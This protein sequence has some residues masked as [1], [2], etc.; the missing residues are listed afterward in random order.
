MNTPSTILGRA[1]VVLATAALCL[2]ATPALADSA[3]THSQPPH[4]RITPIKPPGDFCPKP[5]PPPGWALP[6]Y[7]DIVLPPKP[8]MI[9]KPIQPPLL[10]AMAQAETVGSVSVTARAVPPPWPYPAPYPAPWPDPWPSPNP[11]P[12]PWPSPL[13]GPTF[14]VNV[15]QA[16]HTLDSP[17]PG[18][19]IPK[20]IGGNSGKNTVTSLHT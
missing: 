13:P 10:G 4:E 1:V 14:P 7:C 5:V 9:P 17:D 6:M 12:A 16:N 2:G 20:G 19:P 8:P 3:V 18:M 11:W 15:V